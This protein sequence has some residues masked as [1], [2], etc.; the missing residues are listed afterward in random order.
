MTFID[1]FSHYATIYFMKSKKDSFSNFQKYVV[2]AENETQEKLRCVR[3]NNGGEYTSGVWEK[4]CEEKGIEHSM[5][6][7]HSPQLNGVAERFNRTLLDRILPN[8]FKANLPV[9]FWVE[10]ARHA[11]QAINLS[12]SRTLSKD[13]CPKGV[14]RSK[15]VSYSGLKSFRCKAWRLLTGLQRKDKLSEK[16]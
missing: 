15:E 9:R 10:A 5:G 2:K 6:P 11:V 1:E 14:W 3:S 12:P 16:A 4:F 8:L 13:S 7:P